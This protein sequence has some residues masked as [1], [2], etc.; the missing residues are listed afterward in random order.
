MSRGLAGFFGT[1]ALLAALRV[2]M[3]FLL[4]PEAARLPISLLI[5]VVFVALPVFALFRASSHH[6]DWRL[7]I[8]F[9]ASGLLLQFVLPL[10]SPGGKGILPI[11]LDA[12][13]QQGLPIWTVGLGALLALLLKDKNLLLPVSIF[14]AL[15]DMF[16][17]FTPVGFVQV[18]MRQAPNLLPAMAHK[19]PEVATEPAA[20]G[21][22]VGT[23]A[24]VGPADF[25]FM[26]MFFIALYR[27]RMRTRQTLIWLMVALAVYIPLA[28]ILGPVPLMVPIGLTVILVNLPEFKMTTEE[29]ASTLIVTA[30]GVAI[31]AY[32]ATRPRPVEPAETSPTEP[33]QAPRGLA[34]SPAPA[35]PG[36]RR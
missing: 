1:L 26:G 9:V 3:A 18:L 21:V 6:W 7:A 17:V 35:S 23:F 32:A 25:L 36:P 19:I 10:A 11:L 30:L 27:F 15:F 5:T 29:K 13:A 31:V 4:V 2:A 8:G 16:L 14:L 33:V 24:H 34:G 28:F 22:P 20:T 12:V